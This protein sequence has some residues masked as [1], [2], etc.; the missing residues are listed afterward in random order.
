[1]YF[2]R[3][4]YAQDNGR[5]IMKNNFS[6]VIHVISIFIYYPEADAELLPLWNTFTV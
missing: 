4:E 3:C 5:N 2:F 6:W 1:M